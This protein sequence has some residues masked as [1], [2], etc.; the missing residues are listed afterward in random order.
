[1]NRTGIL[2]LLLLAAMAGRAQQNEK[3]LAD[4]INKLAAPAQ[5]HIGTFILDLEAGDSCMTNAQDHFPMLSVYKFPLALYVLGQVDKGKLSL[6]QPIAIRK[7]EWQRMR[8]PLLDKNQQGNFTLTLQ[9]VL[10]ATVASSDN[11]G[12]DLLFRLI[13]GP[14]IVNTYVHQLG[15]KDINIVYTEMQMAPDWDKPYSNWST[16][17]AMGQLLHLFYSGRLLTPNSTQLLLQWMTE[18]T[19]PKR[20]QGLL[21]AGTLVAHKTGT[22]NTNA[23]G[24]TAATNDV[25]IITLPNGHH[26]VVVVYAADAKADDATRLNV[27]SKIGLAAYNHY[28]H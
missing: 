22:S 4:S 28:L 1:M 25:G 16:P 19:S 24:V 20:I 15:V 12:C 2:P 17:P 23:A 21:P 13:G 14:A 11:V 3:A 8:S 18:S 9:D 7:K 5:G 10:V 27:L 6:E 26:L